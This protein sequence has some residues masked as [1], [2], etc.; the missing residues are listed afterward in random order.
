MQKFCLC[1]AQLKHWS[2]TAITPTPT[3]LPTR[4]WCSQSR[5][6]TRVLYQRPPWGTSWGT[7]HL[8]PPWQLHR[9]TGD[10]SLPLVGRRTNLACPG[11]TK[12]RRTNRHVLNAPLLN[13]V[14]YPH[15][16]PWR[17]FNPR[18][19]TMMLALTRVLGSTAPRNHA[20]PKGAHIRDDLTSRCWRNN[21]PWRIHRA[22]RNAIS[23]SSR[24]RQHSQACLREEI[25]LC[26]VR[27][28]NKVPHTKQDTTHFPIFDCNAIQTNL[29]LFT[30]CC[31]PTDHKCS[32]LE[33]LKH[34]AT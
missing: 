13:H 16:W 27:A 33:H 19:N 17:C 6:K 34:R 23:D 29:E 31:S 7:W 8:E 24:L 12:S 32:Q 26:E 11:R 10:F 9:T 22:R 1:K 2:S 21:T 30:R 25:P 18:G 3:R 20:I 5:R 4:S 15:P 28:P 14:R